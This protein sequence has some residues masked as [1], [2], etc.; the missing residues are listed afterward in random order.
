MR[1]QFLCSRSVCENVIS[2]FNKPLNCC[3]GHNPGS[4]T[5]ILRQALCST[6]ATPA[7]TAAHDTS[8]NHCAHMQ[9]GFS[10]AMCTCRS[11]VHCSPD[12]PQQEHWRAWGK[13]GQ[14]CVQEVPLQDDLEFK[15]GEPLRPDALAPAFLIPFISYMLLKDTASPM[16]LIMAH[17]FHCIVETSGMPDSDV[18]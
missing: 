11:G 1:C 14:I 15:N 10:S 12:Q 16:L 9:I 4:C 3:P 2:L 17:S 8:L 6:D 13:Y 7:L 18:L 5:A